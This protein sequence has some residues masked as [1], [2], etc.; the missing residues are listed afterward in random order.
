MPKVP[1]TVEGAQRL[2]AEL[3]RLKTIERPAVIP[4]SPR[5]ARTATF[6]RTPTTM[7][8]RS[9]KGLSKAALREIESKLANAQVIDPTAID[10]DATS[11]S[12]PPSISKTEEPASA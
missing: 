1:M 10:A 8:Q 7:R 6:P 4:P 3:H 2:K 5:R 9:G 12:A 11:C